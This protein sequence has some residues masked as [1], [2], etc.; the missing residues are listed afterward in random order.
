VDAV[1]A[2]D[3]DLL[4]QLERLVKTKQ[5]MLGRD[6]SGPKAGNGPAKLEEP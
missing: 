5:R 2:R 1:G 3:R 6:G 4:D